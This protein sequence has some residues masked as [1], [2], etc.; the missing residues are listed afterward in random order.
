MGRQFIFKRAV[1]G[2]AIAV[3]MFGVLTACAYTPAPLYAPGTQFEYSPVVKVEE[4]DTFY[5]LARRF[6]VSVDDL[7]HVNRA[8]PPYILR[9]GDVLVLPKPNVHEVRRGESVYS[10]AQLYDVDHERL[11]RLND[12]DAPA[13]VRP[14]TRLR[15]PDSPTGT[16]LPVKKED[17]LPWHYYTP[18]PGRDP[19]VAAPQ[20]R[21]S[22]APSSRPAVRSPA[23]GGRSSAAS[24]AAAPRRAVT[25]QRAAAPQRASAPQRAAVRGPR[26]AWPVQGAIISGFGSKGHGAHNDGINIAVAEGTPVV[27]A[28]TGMVIYRGNAV[29]GFGNLVLVRHPNDLVTAYAHLKDYA[30]SEG[31]RVTQGQT[32]GQAGQTG[33][34]SRPQLHFE[35]RHGV[36]AIDP[37]PFLGARS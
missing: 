21:A 37:L 17:A 11:A 33:N 6:S 18:Q 27:A 19:R 13:W 4:G 22:F 7:I 9:P 3:L 5:A 15:I 32:I 8:E 28:A 30:V 36:N 24:P 12:I 10:I 2:N 20:T 35:L 26:L 16:V 34:V 25:P 29:P 1:R 14:G 31:E 23:R